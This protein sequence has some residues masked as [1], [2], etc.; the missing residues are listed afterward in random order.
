MKQTP[1]KNI[2]SAYKLG[3]QSALSDLEDKLPKE[4][5][6]ISQ[7]QIPDGYNPDYLPDVVFCAGH[8][9]TDSYNICLKEIKSLI[10]S[11]K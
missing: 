9:I 8:N 10:N 5:L 6:T 1:N 7:L 3:Y 4:K 2:S 11:L